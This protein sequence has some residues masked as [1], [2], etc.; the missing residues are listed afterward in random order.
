MTPGTAYGA[1][2]ETRKKLLPL[3]IGRVQEQREHERE[4]ELYRYRDDEEEQN[5]SDARPEVTVLERERVLREAAKD[6]LWRPE[7]SL[8]LRL[9]EGLVDG[10]AD[11]HDVEAARTVR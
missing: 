1:K 5:P 8:P 11:R 6:L 3:T 10:V 4:A 9:E 7:G 2:N